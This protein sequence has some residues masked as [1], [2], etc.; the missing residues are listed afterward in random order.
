ACSDRTK[1]I[2]IDAIAAV[3]ACRLP[4]A[5]VAALGRDIGAA[6]VL[7]APPAPRP[8]G[9]PGSRSGADLLVR[10]LP[11]V[12]YAPGGAAPFGAA[13]PAPWRERIRPVVVSWQHPDGFPGSVEFVGARDYTPWLAA[14]TGLFTLRTL[15]VDAV[16]QHNASLA[17]YGQ[18]VVGSALGV[19][20]ELPP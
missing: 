13:G 7:G 11:Q 18:R 19:D 9:T 4:A 3:T 2:I 12:G 5:R 17:A 1:L 8:P 14:P 6:G 15:G 10:H 16:R 20:D